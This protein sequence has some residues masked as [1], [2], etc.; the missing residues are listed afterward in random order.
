MTLKE[1]VHALIDELPDDSP[2]LEEVRE[3][4]RLDQA[5]AEAYEDI[6]EGRTY[7]AEEF[8]A[9]VHKRWPQKPST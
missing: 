6:R 8:M 3:N 5:L 2:T 9:E 7:T 1:Q 4:L